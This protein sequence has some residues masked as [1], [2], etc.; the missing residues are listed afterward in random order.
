MTAALM[1]DRQTTLLV[2][3]ALLHEALRQ[4]FFRLVSRDFVKGRDRH[5]TASCR[6]WLETLYC[7]L[8]YLLLLD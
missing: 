6:I 1:A 3:A 7:H 8:F 2:A 5:E 4:G